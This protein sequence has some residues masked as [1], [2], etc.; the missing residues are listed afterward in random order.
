MVGCLLMLVALASCSVIDED[1][2]NCQERSRAKLHYE[3]ELVTNMN[4]ELQTELTTQTDIQLAGEIRDKLS[5]IFSDYAHDVDLSFYDTEGD[6]ILLQKDEHIMDANQASYALNLPMRQYMHLAAA[7]VVDNE[8]VSV[9]NDNYCHRSML[10]Q[11]I[12]D[13]IDSHTT[14][15]FTA[16][17]PMEV[18]GDVSQN[19]DVHL[20]MAN[21][22]AALVIDPRE[23]ETL[24]GIRVY[25]SGFAT[26]F[27]ICDSAYQY[28]R[29]APIVRT[30]PVVLENQT[31]GAFVSVTFPSKQPSNVATRNVIETEEPF[32]AEAGDEVLWEFRVYIPH[33]EESSTRGDDEIHITET[34]I[35]VKEPLYPGQLKILRGWIGKNGEYISE[36]PEVSTSVTLDWQD[37]LIIRN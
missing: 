8:L 23:R 14:G 34:I 3:L 32:I 33:L 19:F 30:M 11:V 25:S 35:G 13:T 17:Q 22:A 29:Y 12:R 15:I 6:S 26:G 9:E 5:N 28:D 27:N 37:G 2:S 20:Y 31:E 10:S 18:L 24:D 16:R 21:C 1:L 36:N 7:N 4:T